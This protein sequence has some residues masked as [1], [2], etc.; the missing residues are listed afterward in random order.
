MCRS[1]PQATIPSSR[2]ALISLLLAVSIGAATTASSQS[3]QSGDRTLDPAWKVPEVIAF[4]ALKKGDKVA[5]IVGNRLTASL[6]RTVGPTGTVYA[7]ET[8]QVA[9]LHPELLVG[10]KALAARSPNIVVS[11]EP[12]AT[13]LPLGLDAVV[14]RQNY[15]DLYDKHMAPVDVAVFNKDV[16]TALRPGGVYVVLDHAALA[17]SGIGATEKLHRIDP[18]R[19]KLDVLAAGFDLDAESSML[20]NPGDDHTKSVFDPSVRG[21]TD[22]FLFRFKK[23][24]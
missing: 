22:Q 17:G 1:G 3:A 14:I 8:A 21:H 16:F 15:H 19:V 23:P 10:I 7:I 5:D 18:A 9:K 24:M 20:A 6:A 2:A 12:V 4:I 11:N 13:P